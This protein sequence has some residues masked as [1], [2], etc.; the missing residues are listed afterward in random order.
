MR[1]ATTFF[2]NS[3]K[4][5]IEA[6]FVIGPRLCRVILPRWQHIAWD[7][8][9]GPAICRVLNTDVTYRLRNLLA[10]RSVALIRASPRHGSVGRA[11]LN[12]N[13]KAQFKG[14]FGRRD[15]PRGAEV[16]RG[17]PSEFR[18]VR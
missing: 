10:P 6:R 5:P 18:R 17:G 9:T 3:P 11:I 8:F 4:P 14:E 7:T 2:T 16:S 1:R 13:R 15:R 12:N